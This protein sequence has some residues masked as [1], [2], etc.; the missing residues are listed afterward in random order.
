MPQ[1]LIAF[2]KRFSGAVAVTSYQELDAIADRVL[3]VT[4]NAPYFYVKPGMS[5]VLA[6]GQSSANANFT[7]ARLV[8]PTFLKVAYPQIRPLAYAVSP[9]SPGSDPNL[10]MLLDR[11]LHYDD[12]DTLS[13][14]VIDTASSGTRD[15]YSLVW[16]ETS[17]EP[18]PP[19]ETFWVPYTS[20]TASVANEWTQLAISMDQ[21]PEGEYIICGME[22]FCTD[23]VAAR[24]VIPGSLWRPGVLGQTDLTSRTHRVFY[25]DSLGVWGRFPSFAPPSIEVLAGT[26]GITNH[27]GM[28]RVLRI[29]SRPRA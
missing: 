24:L 14:Q 15:I 10:Q 21:L 25:D 1:H 22:H 9:P 27:T 20:G 6:Y 2:Y 23:C 19:G 28:L 5:I 29:P 4:P 17:R 3:A 8:S 16:I 18:I 13:V 7:R 12:A 26:T 11:P